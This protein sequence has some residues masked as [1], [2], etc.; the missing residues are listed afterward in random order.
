MKYSLVSNEDA[1]AL[2]VYVNGEMKLATSDHPR[3]DDILNGV[4]AGDES[5]VDLFDPA[6][7]VAQRFESITER[8][9]V[10]GSTIYFDGDP[11]DN[12]LTK[13]VVRFLDEG[14][15]DFRPLVNFFEKVV[16]N[17]EQHSREQLYD[18]V[19]RHDVTVNPDGDLVLYKGVQKTQRLGVDQINVYQSGHSGTAIVDGKTYV[20]KI[21]QWVGA[22][23][24]MPRSEVHH[25][26]TN[27]C[28]TG[29]HASSS[30]QL[31]ASYSGQGTI[32]EVVVNPRDV[33]SVPHDGYNKVR[34]N[35]YRVVGVDAVEYGTA[36]VDKWSDDE[37]ED[38]YIYCDYCG[39]IEEDCEFWGG[40]IQDDE[41]DE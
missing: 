32:L 30:A 21:P 8:V 33:V 39:E 24:E 38:D 26:P 9:S 35:R 4:L 17:P 11:V 31:A 36:F 34:V 1:K 2:T 6:K 27:G 29:L 15:E 13:Q 18:W 10:A 16:Q 5:V 40:C 19:S 20:G 22:V 12:S 14:V 25:D 7:A 3:W 41:D 23:V 28:S 37:D